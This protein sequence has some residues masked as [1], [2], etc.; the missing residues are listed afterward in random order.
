[1]LGTMARG[2]FLILIALMF[3]V[4]AVSLS[5]SGVPEPQNDQPVEPWSLIA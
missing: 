4:W 5:K 3:V 2:T 1:M